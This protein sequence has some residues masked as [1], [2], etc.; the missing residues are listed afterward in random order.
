MQANPSLSGRLYVLL[1]LLLLILFFAFV[2]V[3]EDAG[4]CTASG[5][6]VDLATC[7]PPR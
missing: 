1:L 3:T 2:A 5:Y 6:I 4:L 7:T